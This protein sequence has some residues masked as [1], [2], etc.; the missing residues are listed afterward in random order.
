MQQVFC[1]RAGEENEQIGSGE[2]EGQVWILCHPTCVPGR[3]GPW[4]RRVYLQGL[5]TGP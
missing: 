5:G 1:Y 4:I 2:A 3:S